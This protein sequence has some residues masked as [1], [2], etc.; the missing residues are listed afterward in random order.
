MIPFTAVERLVAETRHA[1]LEAVDAEHFDVYT[2]ALFDRLAPLEAR[3]L[4]EHLGA[5]PTEA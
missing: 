1:T 5:A 4:A 2:G 3:F